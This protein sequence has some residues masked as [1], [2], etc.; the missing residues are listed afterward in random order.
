MIRQ[1]GDKQILSSENVRFWRLGSKVKLKDGNNKPTGEMGVVIQGEY[2]TPEGTR[3]FF[4]TVKPLKIETVA[5][6][7]LPDLGGRIVYRG[8][9]EED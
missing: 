4:Q 6:K 2:E 5:P 3:K 8:G 1:E 9:G 7:K